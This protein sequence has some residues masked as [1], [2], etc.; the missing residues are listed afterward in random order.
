MTSNILLSS[1]IILGVFTSSTFTAYNV[2]HIKNLYFVN[3]IH[4]FNEYCKKILINLFPVMV[5]SILL[6]SISLQFIDTEPHN[7]TV[8]LF[9]LSLYAVF[10]ELFYYAYHR[11]VHLKFCYKHIHALHHENINVYPLDAL[12]FDIFDI[13]IG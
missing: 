5:G 12:Y 8:T 6:S 13:L 1:F 3:P 10:V 4:D 2:F 7:L 11:M 9:S